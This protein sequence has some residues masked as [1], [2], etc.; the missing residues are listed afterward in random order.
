M[1][2]ESTRKGVKGQPVNMDKF[3]YSAGETYEITF[4]LSD[5]YQ[6]FKRCKGAN[7]FYMCYSAVITAFQLPSKDYEIVLYPEMSEPQHGNQYQCSICR[8]HVHGT[9]KFKDNKVLRKWLLDDWHY[10]TKYGDIQVNP[11]R[12]DWLDYCKKGMWLWKEFCDKIKYVSYPITHESKTMLGKVDLDSMVTK[13]K[14]KKGI[15][16]YF[17]EISDDDLD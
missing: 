14:S 13:S 4:N 8:F 15:L 2:L 9:I 11:L 10:I 16:E 6:Y 1:S 7:R 3:H 5:E 12:K 17:D